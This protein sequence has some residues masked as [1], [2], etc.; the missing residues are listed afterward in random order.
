MRLQILIE[1]LL[2][3]FYSNFFRREMKQEIMG[4]NK[5]WFDHGKDKSHA[6]KKKIRKIC[7][8]TFPFV[9]FS[10]GENRKRVE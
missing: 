6:R 5:I 3:I 2:N 1:N 4:K 10:N 7:K 8:L 9:L